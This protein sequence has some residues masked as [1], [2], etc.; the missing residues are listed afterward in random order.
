[1]EEQQEDGERPVRDGRAVQRRPTAPVHAL[2]KVS[3]F[4]VRDNEHVMFACVD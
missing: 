1:M 2:K 3:D 4:A